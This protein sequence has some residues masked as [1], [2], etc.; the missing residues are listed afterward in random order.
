MLNFHHIALAKPI[1]L[2][3]HAAIL[4]NQATGKILFEK[5]SR[6]S[7]YP[8]S[9]TKIATCAYILQLRGEKIATLVE[10]ENEAVAIISSLAKKRSGYTLPSWWLDSGASHMAIK[11]GEM[12]S[13]EDLLSGAMIASA[14]D[15]CNILAM[16][17]GGTVPEF[18]LDIN[19][20]LK[21]W[22]LSDTYFTNPHGLHHPDHRTTAFDLSLLCR[23]A[24]EIPK[25][26]E[27]VQKVN[28]TRNKTN[29]SDPVT[30]YQSNALIKKGP[31]HYPPAIGIKTGYTEAAGYCLAAAAQK[32]GR[33]L[34]VILLGAPSKEVL[35]K[36]AIL[37][38]ETA[39]SE[40]VKRGLVLKAGPVAESLT[41][42]GGSRAIRPLLEQDLILD[43]YPMEEPDVK[44]RIEWEA[45][46]LPIQKG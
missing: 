35:Y 46:D 34:L 37:L 7:T 18:M 31:Y 15:A 40:P 26:R 21:E 39:F 17:I 20:Q 27:I 3:T 33:C 2:E 36:E 30:L 25:F 4:L 9:L 1:E 23:R 41:L 5:N 12:V 28:Y 19:A 22:G 6:E 24:F 11:A 44:M 43:Y 45:A 8:A 29:K 14:G 32:G 38:F 10:A 13:I 42:P 16:Y